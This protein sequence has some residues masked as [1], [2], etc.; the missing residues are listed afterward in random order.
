MQLCYT[1]TAVLPGTQDRHADRQAGRPS[2]PLPR[3]RRCRRLSQ[4]GQPPPCRRSSCTGAT[5]VTR[6]R[7]ACVSA[8]EFFV[9]FRPRRRGR[10]G[11]ILKKSMSPEFPESHVT[12]QPHY[13]QD[14]MCPSRLSRS[15]QVVT[16]STAVLF[17]TRS[18]GDGAATARGTSRRV[19]GQCGWDRRVCGG[20]VGPASCAWRF[21]LGLKD[22]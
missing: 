3:A 20:C 1:H 7:P 14:P 10:P 13:T 9:D 11:R 2:G 12:G 6:C 16:E 17:D 5:C 8:V 19:G 18:A 4:R 15:T 21:A 22:R